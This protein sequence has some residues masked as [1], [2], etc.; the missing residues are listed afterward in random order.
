MR[1]RTRALMI[2][3]APYSGR[4]EGLAQ[5]LGIRNHCIHYLSFQRPWVAPVKYPLQAAT[6]LR[7]LLRERPA[8]VLAQNP[9]PLAPLVA[10]LYARATGGGFI[11]DSHS[12]PFF[13]RRWA[14]TLPLQRWLARRALA[15]VVTNEHLA[16]IVRG[17]GA[18]ALVAV[19]PPIVFPPLGPRRPAPEFTVVVVS[20]FAADEPIEAVLAAAQAVPD[21][22][23]A[24][25]GDLAYARPK[26][27][28]TPPPNVEFTGFL[29][30]AAYYPRIWHANALVVLTTYDHTVLRG[31]WEALDLG[32]PLVLSN[33]PILRQYFRRGTVFVDNTAASIAAAVREVRAREDALRAEM[34]ALRDE[35]RRAWET[36]R[37]QL[38]RLL[39]NTWAR[40]AAAGRVAPRPGRELTVDAR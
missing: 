21:V 19:D 36:A 37:A 28:A 26:W 2:T 30:R 29:Q 34:L 13:I 8:V 5:H 11:M 9:P 3:W 1:F 22:R 24:I 7:L 20:T 18:P 10:A 25:T 17:W 31:A 39:D 6:T 15:T 32:Q 33:W 16:A 38:E 35:R 14:W 27:L 40:A 12:E 4:S 23:F